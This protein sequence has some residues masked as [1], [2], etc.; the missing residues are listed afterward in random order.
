MLPELRVIVL[1]GK[2]AQSA[3]NEIRRL[4][5][6]PLVLT[7]HPSARVFNVWPEKR[8]ESGSHF[9]QVTAML[10]VGDTETSR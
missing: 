6:V 8:T 7:H 5:D 2:K 10:G 4:T 9:A 1:V 3:A